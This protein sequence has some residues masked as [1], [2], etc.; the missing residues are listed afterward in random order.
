L[1]P[2]TSVALQGSTEVKLTLASAPGAGAMLRYAYR[3]VPKTCAGA[4]LGARGNLRDSDA[5][6]SNYGYELFN[7]AI[8]F[9]MEIK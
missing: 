4:Q 6:P 9:E 8:H 5:T 1:I 7:W 2:I 3:H